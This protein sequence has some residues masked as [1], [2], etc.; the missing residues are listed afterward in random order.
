MFPYYLFNI[1]S[2][3]SDITFFSCVFFPLITVAR[4]LS[5]VLFFSKNH[6]L[7]SLTFLCF[8]FLCFSLIK[9]CSVWANWSLLLR[10]DPSAYFVHCHM[11]SEI[12]SHVNTVLSSALGWFF[13]QP[14][15]VS[16]QACA[17]LTELN[18]WG[19]PLQL[20]RARS[21]CTSLQY[22]V[23]SALVVF[24]S[25][26]SQLCLFNSGSPL[27]SSRV[28]VP[29]PALQLGDKLGQS[30]GSAHLF[31]ASQGLLPSLL[32]VQC[33][34]WKLLLH[35]FCPFVVV[36]GRRMNPILVTPSW[37]GVSPE[38]FTSYFTFSSQN[39]FASFFQGSLFSADVS[40]SVH[41]MYIFPAVLEHF[42]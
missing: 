18:T 24:V 40:L 22:S 21:L 3:C 10:H 17:A 4:G 2:I 11:R 32:E 6:L 5:I 16:S 35:L 23:Q 9:Q 13:P 41:Y 29:F 42:L 36:S 12:F 31:P 37:L 15:V 30:W 8:F 38:F 25:L 26:D 39:P 1:C 34:P 27:V 33:Q 14:R 28:R 19:D 20:S 7:G